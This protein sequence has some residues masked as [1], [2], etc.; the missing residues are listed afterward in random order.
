MGKNTFDVL[1]EENIFGVHDKVDE[2][3]GSLK[4]EKNK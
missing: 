3:I 1:Q 2:S 4:L